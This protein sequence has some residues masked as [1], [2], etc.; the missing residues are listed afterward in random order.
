VF[1]SAAV[2]LLIQEAAETE[3]YKVAKAAIVR[4]DRIKI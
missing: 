2:A 4:R 1:P 3:N